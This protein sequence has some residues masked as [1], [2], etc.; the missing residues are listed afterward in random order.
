MDHN[1]DTCTPREA[2][3]LLGVSIKTVKHWGDIGRLPSWRTP[4][5]HRRFL[6]AALTDITS[7]GSSAWAAWKAF[8]IA[9]HLLHNQSEQ[10]ELLAALF[11]QQLPACEISTAADIYDSLLAIGKHRPHILIADFDTIRE[12]NFGLLETIANNNGLSGIMIIL[13]GGSPLEHIDLQAKHGHTCSLLEDGNDTGQ[14]LSMIKAYA[15]GL[16]SQPGLR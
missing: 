7:D 9:L 13:I 12:R 3:E 11:K 16:L 1:D 2:A 10:R 14:L 15:M 4:G 6:R 8:P 5:G